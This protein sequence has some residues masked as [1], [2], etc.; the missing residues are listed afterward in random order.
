MPYDPSP[1]ISS[2]SPQDREADQRVPALIDIEWGWLRTELEP[3]LSRLAQ[4]QSGWDSYGAPAIS[5][6]ALVHARQIAKIFAYAV[7]GLPCP[8]VLPTPHGG[9]ALEWES[10]DHYATIEVSSKGWAVAY[11]TDDDEIEVDDPSDVGPFVDALK[12]L[13]ADR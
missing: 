12:R 1:V 8:H 7:P 3:K 6:R 4:L 2:M 13:L 10:G 5:G 11:S 9:V